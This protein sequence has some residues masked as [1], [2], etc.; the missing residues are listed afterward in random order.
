MAEHGNPTQWGTGFPPE[1]LLRKDIGKKQLYIVEN[2]T[3]V[4]GVFFFDIMEDPTYRVI[5]GGE[6]SMEGPYGVIHRIAGDGEVPG[7]L[8]AALGFAEQRTEYLRIDTH[9]RNRTMQAALEKYGF[10]RCGIIHVADGS[11]RIAFDR[12]RHRNNG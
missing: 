12:Y 2:E 5:T 3:A 10:R 11:P 7:I 9:E 8:R 6:W 4:H 1:D